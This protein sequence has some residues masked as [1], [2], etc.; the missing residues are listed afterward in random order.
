MPT[1]KMQEHNSNIKTNYYDN[2]DLQ[3]TIDNAKAIL[4]RI[5]KGDYQG[6]ID[7]SAIDE[8]PV[9]ENVS[10]NENKS[11]LQSRIDKAISL[12]RPISKDTEMASNGRPNVFLRAGITKEYKNGSKIKL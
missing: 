6:L 9:V 4:G 1:N 11:W 2:I 7:L 10:K 12:G 8:N 3:A 5:N